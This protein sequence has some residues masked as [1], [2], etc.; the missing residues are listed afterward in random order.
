MMTTHTAQLLDRHDAT[1]PVIVAQTDAGR[2]LRI[3]VPEDLMAEAQRIHG[4]GT[5]RYQFRGGRPV[6]ISRDEQ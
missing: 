1:E 3:R 5:V 6:M 4:G 2:I